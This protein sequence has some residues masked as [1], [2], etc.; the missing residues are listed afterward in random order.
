MEAATAGS[1]KADTQLARPDA[2]E[3]SAAAASSS[4]NASS[5]LEPTDGDLSEF[6]M[7]MFST[8][9]PKNLVRPPLPGS[10]AFRGVRR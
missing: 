7:D 9:K 5:S 4:A 10:Q 3:T 1:R 6:G 8:R 2:P